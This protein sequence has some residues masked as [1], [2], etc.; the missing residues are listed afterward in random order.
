MI[1]HLLQ[2][3]GVHGVEN[4]VEIVSRWAFAL[5]EDIWKV[6]PHIFVIGELWPDILH[7]ELIVVGDLNEVDF[8]LPEQLLLLG[9]YLFE[10][11]FI[12]GVGRRQ[13]ELNYIGISHL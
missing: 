13:V 5:W 11:V 4:I 3:V 10:E 9:K 12:D 6:L 7:A 1:Q 2:V 8:L